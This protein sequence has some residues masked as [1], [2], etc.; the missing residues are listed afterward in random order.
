MRIVTACEPDE[1]SFSGELD[2]DVDGVVREDGFGGEVREVATDRDGSAVAVGPK[3]AREGES[4][5]SGL[6]GLQRDPA[7]ARLHAQHVRDH[8]GHP[9]EAAERN[10]SVGEARV[11]KGAAEDG[12]RMILDARKDH[13]D[14]H[15]VH[16]ASTLHADIEARTTK[17]VT[18]ERRACGAPRDLAAAADGVLLGQNRF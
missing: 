12:E 17:K 6:G 4:G 11:V 2:D 5:E 1:R 13:T 3:Q 8:L 9:G 18:R 10:N 7:D 15:D 14:Q 16:G